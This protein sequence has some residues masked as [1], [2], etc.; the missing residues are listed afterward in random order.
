MKYRCIVRLDSGTDRPISGFVD[1][2]NFAERGLTGRVPLVVYSWLSWSKSSC[3]FFWETR[4]VVAPHW[5]MRS[6]CV[7]VR[8]SQTWD[9]FTNYYWHIPVLCTMHFW[10]WHLCHSWQHAKYDSPCVQLCMHLWLLW[11]LCH[12]WCHAKLRI[13]MRA[14]MYALVIVK[15]VS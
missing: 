2:E 3:D 10:L 11:N 8:T 12:S 5:L 14:I 1:D 15:F 4:Q 13:T 6:G 7:K 9:R